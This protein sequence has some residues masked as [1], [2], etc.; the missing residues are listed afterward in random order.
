MDRH[1]PHP[2]VILARGGRLALAVGEGGPCRRVVEEAAQVAAI[3]RLVL[4]RDA[5][6]L[7]QVR[8]APPSLVHEQRRE[9]VV[10]RLE[11]PLH[12]RVE[13]EGGG[14]RPQ[15]R[16]PLVEAGEALL[17]IRRDPRLPFAQALLPGERVLVLIRRRLRLSE[18]Q[19]ERRPEVGAGAGD[20]AQDPQ[21][22]RARAAGGGGERGD[23]RL[24]VERVGDASEEGERVGDLLR[25]P[26]AAAAD[27][28]R[29]EAG[30][31]QR[32]RV[33][34]DVGEGAQQDHHPRRIDA[35]VG[36]LAAGAAPETA[37]RRPGRA[38]RRR[39]PSGSV[40][41]VG[42]L[43]PPSQQELDRRSP[44]GPGGGPSGS[45]PTRSSR[46]SS[47]RA[48]PTAL[49]APTTSGSE[50]KLPERGAE[51]SPSPA[52]PPPAPVGARARAGS[53]R[54]RP[55]GRRRS[56]GTRPRRR[57]AAWTARR[58]LARARSG[59]GSCPG[60]RRRAGGRSARAGP[61]RSC[62][63]GAADRAR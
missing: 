9:V 33:D 50:R 27:D 40:L 31:L 11:R 54:G 5:D 56:T 44:A 8:R 51:P 3:V 2:R 1:H 16:Q 23:Q 63:C 46:N 34:V 57:T 48:A 21:R 22:V 19:L 61:R 25:G 53:S 14:D 59:S 37:P 55:L 41:R 30:E 18:Q 28:V 52:A 60:T 43:P 10:E 36:E 58:A 13:R 6:E 20:A 29:L 32:L 12:E 35:A 42:P 45:L 39:A 49:T 4:G 26:V 62:G 17:V 38:R 7:A 47:R 24:V 15:I